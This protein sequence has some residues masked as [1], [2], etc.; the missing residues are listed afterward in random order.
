MYTEVLDVGT[1]Q[2]EIGERKVQRHRQISK[3]KTYVSTGVW[4]KGINYNLY[5]C[6]DVYVIVECFIDDE[7]VHFKIKF[8]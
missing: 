5:H 4:Q 2:Y 3:D 1:N 6:F 7:T 8:I